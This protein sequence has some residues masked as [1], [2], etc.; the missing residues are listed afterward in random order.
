MTSELDAE[1]E[2]EWAILYDSDQVSA[3]AILRGERR[4]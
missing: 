3:P 2:R 4:S 1:Q